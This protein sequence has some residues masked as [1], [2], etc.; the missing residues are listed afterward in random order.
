M[1]MGR[2][3]WRIRLD[4]KIRVYEGV[5]ETFL[6]IREQRVRWSR[7]TI[8]N[9]ARHGIYR[10][11]GRHADGLVHPDVPVLLG[12]SVHRSSSLLPLYVAVYSRVR[13]RLE[14]PP[15]RGSHLPVRRDR[16]SSWCSRCSSRARYGFT[17]RIGWVLLW[18]LWRYCLTMFSTESLL[19]LPGRPVPSFTRERRVIA[20]A[21]VRRF[22]AAPEAD[23]R[24][25]A[26]SRR[27]PGARAEANADE[28]TRSITA[29]GTVGAT[30]IVGASCD[31][32]AC[33][34]VG[35]SSCIRAGGAGGP[36]RRR[37]F[38]N[39]GAYLGAWIATPP[40]AGAR[41][42]AR[43]Q[44]PTRSGRRDASHVPQPGNAA[45]RTSDGDASRSRSR[46]AEHRRRGC[47]PG[48]ELG[49]RSPDQ[50]INDGFEDAHI[51]S[52]A[53]TLRA[54]GRPVFLRVRVGNE[55]RGTAARGEPAPS[56]DGPAGFGRLR[57][58]AS[59]TSSARWG[60]RQ[61][62]VRLVPGD[63]AAPTTGSSLLPGR[64]RRRLDR[65]RRIRAR[66]RCG[67]GGHGV[68]GAVRC[69]LRP[70]RRRGEAVHGRRDRRPP[71]ERRPSICR[72]SRC[73]SPRRIRR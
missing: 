48:R 1:R 18:P 10:A 73:S 46:T 34:D 43:R 52:Y 12:T 13:K 27:P 71:R 60:R 28:P 17:R 35:A 3:G 29:P 16:S 25:S 62:G 70:V 30:C 8:H 41:Q 68:P 45:P 19:S 7:A 21:V 14:D 20:E 59:A 64:R 9:Q 36:G 69:L 42:R 47:G 63:L 15:P 53:E 57:G 5:P 22:R 67:G 6:E 33:G 49:L 38:P 61:R 11:G 58:D 44:P 39:C 23:P 72:A 40:R 66:C 31:I 26:R 2:L 32:G 37:R 54:F 4:P 65:H 24:S 56:A 50:A 51:R 55:P